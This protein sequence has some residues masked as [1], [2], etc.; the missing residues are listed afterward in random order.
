VRFTLTP[1]RKKKPP[2]PP[3]D[4]TPYQ[5]N[6][7]AV[8]DG[9]LVAVAKTAQELM[10]VL[11]SSEGFKGSTAWFEEYPQKVMRWSV[12]YA[13]S[14]GKVYPN[15]LFMTREAAEEWLFSWQGSP[16]D[17]GAIYTRDGQHEPWRPA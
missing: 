16:G 4:F 6:W 5:G 10:D 17:E 1:W 9:V 3:I 2:P 7:V 8:K 13:S 14:L 12:Q 11:T 15:C